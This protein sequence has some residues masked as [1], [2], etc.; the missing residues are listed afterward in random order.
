MALLLS[1]GVSLFTGFNPGGGGGGSS[2]RSEE[3]AGTSAGAVAGTCA[4]ETAGDRA[5]EIAGE[6]SGGMNADPCAQVDCGANGMCVSDAD[7]V[8]CQ[9][10]EGYIDDA[11]TCVE[12]NPEVGLIGTNIVAVGQEIPLRAELVGG[13]TRIPITLA[14]VTWAAYIEETLIVSE[15]DCPRSGPCLVIVEREGV[16]YVKGIT[17]GGGDEFAPDGTVYIKGTHNGEETPT[18]PIQVVRL[19]EGVGMYPVGEV[20]GSENGEEAPSLSRYDGLYLLNDQEIKF[21]CATDA[22]CPA[23]LSCDAELRACVKG[24]GLIERSVAK[25]CEWNAEECVVHRADI[26]VNLDSTFQAQIRARAEV[27]EFQNK[28][29]Y[30][31]PPEIECESAADCGGSPCVSG[32]CQLPKVYHPIYIE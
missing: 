17:R 10:D 7:D 9:C 12:A 31:Q 22:E 2:E 26:R 20:V 18:Y 32:T 25:S 28:E 23:G 4:G 29:L 3:M 27:A 30:Y 5:G 16:S 13:Q 19:L 14:E 24:N 11:L 6:I 15:A 21:Y 8:S 1:F